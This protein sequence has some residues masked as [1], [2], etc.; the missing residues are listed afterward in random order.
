M[1]T[2]NDEEQRQDTMSRPR[3]A[4]YAEIETLIHLHSNASITLGPSGTRV[5]TPS[6]GT[7]V[8]TS[9]RLGSLILCH[10]KEIITAQPAYENWVVAANPVVSNGYA[11]NRGT[12]MPTA[13]VEIGFH[14]NQNDAKAMQQSE[15]QVAAVKGIVKAHGLH[16]EG[17][18]V[19]TPFEA[20]GMPD[21]TIPFGTTSTIPVDYEGHPEFDVVIEVDVVSCAPGWTCNPANVVIYNET[22]SPLRWFIRCNGFQSFPAT[23]RFRVT[24]RDIDGVKTTP[25]E[26]TVTCSPTG[27]GEDI[28]SGDYPVVEL[29]AG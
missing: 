28:D 19:C 11:E 15:F 7:Q 16:M 27:T 26:N 6:L 24:L 25:L 13:L 4:N 18:S 14:T 21:V 9:E 5:Y 17:E 23:H 12:N 3:W 29:T 20:T 22:P 2:G 8:A 10:M 1:S